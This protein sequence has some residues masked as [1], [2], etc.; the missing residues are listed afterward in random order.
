MQCKIASALNLTFKTTPINKS[1]YP[2]VLRDYLHL[3]KYKMYKQR[4][5]SLSI[6]VFFFDSITSRVYND[7]LLLLRYAATHFN[8]R[9]Y[10]RQ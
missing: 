2:K 7:S 8:F 1:I 4:R 3:H 10:A 9:K 5:Y 6:Y